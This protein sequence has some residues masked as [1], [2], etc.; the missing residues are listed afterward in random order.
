MSEVVHH[1]EKRDSRG[2]AERRRKTKAMP[3]SAHSASP[4]E[5]VLVRAVDMR[6]LGYGG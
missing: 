1:A 4:R 2:G 3:V 5:M 6:G